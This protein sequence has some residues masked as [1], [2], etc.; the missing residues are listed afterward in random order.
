MISSLYLVSKLISL[1][2]SSR[3]AVTCMNYHDH[4]LQDPRQFRSLPDVQPSQLARVARSLRSLPRDPDTYKCCVAQCDG[5]TDGAVMTVIIV[6][7][8]TCCQNQ[9]TVDKATAIAQKPDLPQH[10]FSNSGSSAQAAI[11]PGSRSSGNSRSG[12]AG[13]LRWTLKKV[14]VR[15]V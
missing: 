8:K 1:E 12:E 13:E 10:C 9:H 6:I 11:R 2:S 15:V 14:L 4:E 5:S 3:A 7:V